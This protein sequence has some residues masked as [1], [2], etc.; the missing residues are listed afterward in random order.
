MPIWLYTIFAGLPIFNYGSLWTGNN[1][2]D[3]DPLR[4]FKFK[5]P[6][7]NGNDM[8]IPSDEI[9]KLEVRY[10]NVGYDC[11]ALAGWY[12]WE[13]SMILLFKPYY[14]MI[15][16]CWF[17]CFIHNVRSVKKDTKCS[18]ILLLRLVSFENVKF[19]DLQVF[20]FWIN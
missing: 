11:E 9:E 16:I 7:V 12:L 5:E 6:E 14:R 3:K 1:D 20:T 2:F 19:F 8:T 15:F 13:W 17:V 10:E 18:S 4:I